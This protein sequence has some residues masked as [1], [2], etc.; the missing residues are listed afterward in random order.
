[1][2]R[3]HPLRWVLVAAW[4]TALY[5][6]QGYWLAHSQSR[7]WIPNFGLLLTLTLLG[8][9]QREDLAKVGLAMTVARAAVSIDPPIAIFAAQAFVVVLAH[10]L[11]RL[12]EISQP[13]PRSLLAG[14][15][16]LLFAAWYELVHRVRD[17]RDAA[18]AAAEA[19]RGS[20]VL[21]ALASAWPSA[22]TTA[23]VALL[24][25][26]AFA[27]LPGLVPLWKKR[28]WHAVA[29]LR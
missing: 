26:P 1:V 15:N 6:A 17:A 13:V 20:A 27:H 25:G 3:V 5:A 23:L 18:L 21:D 12:L 8:R 11:R 14:G 7:A 19:A 28:P 10:T 22:L 29:S 16:A 9:V 2:T 24:L 4:G